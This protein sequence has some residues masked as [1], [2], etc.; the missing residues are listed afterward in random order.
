M[1]IEECADK[2]GQPNPSGYRLFENEDGKWFAVRDLDFGKKE[3][4]GPLDRREDA[5]RVLSHWR[6]ADENLYSQVYEMVVD[7][8]LSGLS[9]R[10]WDLT[11]AP[12][13]VD[14]ASVPDAPVADFPVMTEQLRN[15]FTAVG[16]VLWDVAKWFCR[17][18]HLGIDAADDF[19]LDWLDSCEKVVTC[20]ICEDG[21]LYF[22][23]KLDG[24]MH[25]GKLH[26]DDLGELQ[27]MVEKHFHSDGH[28][29]TENERIRQL[30]EQ[31]LKLK[32]DLDWAADES[33]EYREKWERQCRLSMER[34]EEMRRLGAENARLIVAV[35][36]NRLDAWHVR[37]ELERLAVTIECEHPE[38]GYPSPVYGTSA[39]EA[40]EA[41]VNHKANREFLKIIR[42]IL[43]TN[44][45]NVRVGLEVAGTRDDLITQLTDE[46]LRLAE[47]RGEANRARGSLESQVDTLKAE[48]ARLRESLQT[49]NNA[50]IDV[51][52]QLH[53]LR[54]AVA[55]LAAML[56]DISAW[57]AR[58]DELFKARR[59]EVAQACEALGPK[60]WAE[61]A[62]KLDAIL[63]GAGE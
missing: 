62:N 8:L 45:D 13:P 53:A 54:K 61:V 25:K 30:E 5:V 37:D 19:S 44:T 6:I 63:K 15:Q 23:A 57:K 7:S 49:H 55:G 10:E 29:K 42:R 39:K 58:N 16:R 60:L 22:A 14:A 32:C 17:P 40:C 4:R 47:E 31:V 43:A 27:A 36:K 26:P 51:T 59:T 34:L 56:R 35:E 38:D 3:M 18:P 33:K 46:N 20:S 28:K 12:C 2:F 48:N 11:D 9:P 41:R 50:G 52:M 1:T 24:Q 21:Y